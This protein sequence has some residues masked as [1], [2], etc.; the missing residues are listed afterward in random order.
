MAMDN[1][2]WKRFELA[3]WLSFLQSSFCLERLHSFDNRENTTS[4]FSFLSSQHSL[5]FYKND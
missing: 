2:D 5:I 3:N 4:L 1:S